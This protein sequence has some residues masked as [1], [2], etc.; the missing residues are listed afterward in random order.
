M[1]NKIEIALSEKQILHSWVD[2][3]TLISED[4]IFITDV[5]K[6]FQ[7]ILLSL[8]DKGLNFIPEHILKES[9]EFVNEKTITSILET[10][11]QA[12]KTETYKKDLF[13]NTQILSLEDKV[14]KEL[15]IEISKK[16]HKDFEAIKTLYEDFGNILDSIDTK[17]EEP[18]TFYDALALHEPVL[19]QRSHAVSKTTG[20]YM[21]DKIMPNIVPGIAIIGGFSGSMKTTYCNYLTKQ[22]IVKRLPTVGINTELAF[23][24]Y[25]DNTISSMIKEPY[26]D[27]LGISPDNN[28]SMIDYT[29]IMG[30][31]E[32]LKKRYKNR[33][34]FYL[35][36]RNSCS[37][38]EVKPF[39]VSSRK[40]MKLKDD[41][42]LFCFVDLLSMLDEFGN[43]ESGNNKADI[44]EKGVNT[45]NNIGLSTNTLIIG[46]IQMKRVE[47]V[48]RIEREEDIEKFRPTL[49]GLKSSGSWEERARWVMVLHNPYHI[50]HK[51]PCN[52]I[53]Q[54][55]IDPILEL[56][57]LKDTYTGKTGDTIKYY[58]NSTYKSLL[59]YEEVIE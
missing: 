1:S 31:Y 55:T 11:Y 56:T 41:E 16:G 5:A 44:I 43:N 2:N 47:P 26:Y 25:M 45:L 17:K 53:I 37:I 15:A 22:R 58:F 8:Q 9:V 19:E 7:Y 38:K 14:L 36:P 48:K 27:I 12:D 46:T 10:S 33:N 40:K 49:A 4:D 23:N 50:V 57:I 52:P 39:L 18:L 32:G 59:P 54:D 3:P 51:T 35:F 30:K 13:V 34:N 24:G 42:T 28:N 6:E 20:C 29:S 21:L